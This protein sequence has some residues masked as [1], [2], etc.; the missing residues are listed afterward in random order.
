MDCTDSTETSVL[1]IS[2]LGCF[3]NLKCWWCHYISVMYFITI[4]SLW[5]R[6]RL[7]SPA[8]PLVSQ[9]FIQAHIKEKPKL[10]VT[11][12]LRGINRRPVNS[13]HKGPVP[14]KTFLFHDVIMFYTNCFAS[15]TYRKCFLFANH[16][17]QDTRYHVERRQEKR[18]DTILHI[19]LIGGSVICNGRRIH[20]STQS[21]IVFSNILAQIK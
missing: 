19:S 20:D 15:G 5:T 12:L 11:G 17:N 16:L 10:R 7:K 6:W 9:L 2:F 8:S 3:L 13:S 4:T 14:R 21:I 1:I 18:T